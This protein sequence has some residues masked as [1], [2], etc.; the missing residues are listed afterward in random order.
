VVVLYVVVG[1][2]I[3]GTFVVRAMG[4]RRALPE[5]FVRNRPGTDVRA[6]A[7]ESRSVRRYVTP[8]AARWLA[9]S[10]A[11]GDHQYRRRAKDRQTALARRRA[12]R[13]CSRR[14]DPRPRHHPNDQR[15]ERTPV[16]RRRLSGTLGLVPHAEF[17]H[18]SIAFAAIVG[19]IAS[20]A[21]VPTR[22]VRRPERQDAL[23]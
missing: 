21:W 20:W 14:G 6:A 5:L 8:T 11:L 17:V 10:G 13:S 4:K 1:A 16:H 3:I 2:L 12:T 7:L 9:G 18:T 15:M 22:L 19:V 23:A